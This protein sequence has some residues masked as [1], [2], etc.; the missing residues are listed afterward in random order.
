MPVAWKEDEEFARIAVVETGLLRVL[1]IMNHVGT[2]LAVGSSTTGW[3]SAKLSARGAVPGLL[4]VRFPG[5]P[6]EPGVRLSPHRALHVRMVGQLGVA[7]VGVH[8]VGMW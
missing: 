4:G 5:P 7:A 6:A 8:G 2:I 1:I 3:N